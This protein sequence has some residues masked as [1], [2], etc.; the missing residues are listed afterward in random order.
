MGN[1]EHM[2]RTV[3]GNTLAW[4]VGYA[5][6]EWMETRSPADAQRAR[7]RALVLLRFAWGET[8]RGRRTGPA[9]PGWF[10]LA[11][12][13]LDALGDGNAVRVFLMR[14]KTRMR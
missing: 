7:R 3:D 2:A 10:G 11:A 8:S 9:L 4:N 12:A 1:G 6:L 13:T 14:H 5:F